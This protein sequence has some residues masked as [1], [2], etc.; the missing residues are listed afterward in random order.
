MGIGTKIPDKKLTVKGKIHTEELIVEPD[1]MPD[2]VF[3]K[4]YKLK[5][6]NEI[7]DYVKSK[8]HL[9]EIPSAIEIKEKGLY[10]GEMQTKLL[11]KIEE[12]VLY[13]I[14]LKKDQEQV[15]IH[16]KQ[17]LNQ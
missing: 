12:L 16:L 1:I 13:F 8:K 11:K 4:D 10:I 6:L 17:L 2:Y 5:S 14:E 9:P 15:K 3:E 7:N